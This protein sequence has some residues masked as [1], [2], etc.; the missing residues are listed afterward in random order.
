MASELRQFNVSIPAGTLAAT[1]QLTA[2]T[3]PARIV[4]KIRVRV[5]RGPNGLVGFALASSGVP[6]IPW[7]TGAWI[8]ADDEIFEWAL[9][10]Q[11]T[12]GAWQ[13]RAY[14]TGAY[15]HTLYLSFE[16]DPPQL[17]LPGAGLGMI[18]IGELN[19]GTVYSP[20]PGAGDLGGELPPGPDPEPPPFESDIGEDP[21]VDEPGEPPLPPADPAD[22]YAVARVNA[23]AAVQAALGAT[24]TAPAQLPPAPGSVARLS[25]DQGRQAAIDALG[26]I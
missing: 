13:L 24:I 25:Y 11:I 20:P 8:V 9:E 18:P 16:L 26:S 5:P 12:S 15:A 22:G 1:P 17:R 23:T 3:M 14:N 7:N 6:I 4:R 21:I 10:R 19:S 2:L